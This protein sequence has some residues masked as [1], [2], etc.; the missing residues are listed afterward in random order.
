LYVLDTNV[1]SA[2]APGKGDKPPLH[3]SL[4]RWIERRA[5]D[6]FLSSIT[7][8]EI[9]AGLFRLGRRSQG[10][11]HDEMLSW[12]DVLLVQFADRVLSVDL[13]VA[14]AAAAITDRNRASGLVTGIAD[15]LI[16]ATALV[17]GK[18]LLTRNTRH[19]TGA[20]VAVID[21]FESLPPW[22]R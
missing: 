9:E 17:N 7:A 20:G 10:R 4:L 2:F 8:L 11:W 12:Y 19:F 16:A 15:T 13:A 5:D 3:P 14:R 6:L 1:I 21:P 18:T 22:A